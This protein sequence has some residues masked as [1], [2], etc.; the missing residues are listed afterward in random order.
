MIAGIRAES[1]VPRRRLFARNRSIQT[2]AGV[3]LLDFP[4]RECHF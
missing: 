2:R 4:A 3:S 1:D